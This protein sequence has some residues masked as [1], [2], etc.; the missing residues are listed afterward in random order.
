MEEAGRKAQVGWCGSGAA[1]LQICLAAA[2]SLAALT[3]W[4]TSLLSRPFSLSFA[5]SLAR[6]GA[7]CV[8]AVVGLLA[9]SRTTALLLNYGAP[10]TI[11]RHLPQVGLRWVV[12]GPC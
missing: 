7:N 12:G 10:M 4:A 2:A 1:L 6:L 8:L 11:Y 5:R 9:L 3:S